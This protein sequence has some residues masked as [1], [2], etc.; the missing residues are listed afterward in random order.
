MTRA[1][2]DKAPEMITL[3]SGDEDEQLV[4]QIPVASLKNIDPDKKD[5]EVKAL[6]RFAIALGGGKADTLEEDLA[7]V[8]SIDGALLTLPGAEQPLSIQELFGS[9]LVAGSAEDVAKF[10]ANSELS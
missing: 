3:I 8:L 6:S 9:L 2:I 1:D 10:Q 7:T 5:K 4:L